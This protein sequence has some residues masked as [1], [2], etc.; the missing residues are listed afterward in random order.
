MKLPII[1][2][3]IVLLLTLIPTPQAYEDWTIDGN[4][5]YIDTPQVY[6]SATPHTLG[7]D[8][9]VTFNFTSKQYTGNIDFVWGF[10]TPATTPHQPQLWCNYSHTLTATR[11]KEKSQTNQF[12][13]ITNYSNLG[14][15]NFHLYNVDFG[16]T[17]NTF[18]YHIYDQFG[19][20]IIAFT[21]FNLEEETT[22][23]Y[24]DSTEQYTYQQSYFDWKP[25]TQ[26]F[27]IINYEYQDMNT[28]YLL[29]NTPITQGTEY[30]IRAWIDIP[31]NGLDNSSGKYWWAFKPYSET[32]Q[33]SIS[34]NHFYC[35]DPWWNSNWDYMCVITIDTDFITTA[36]GPNI[37]VL[38][39][40]QPD[41]VCECDGGDSIRFLSLDNT[42]EFNYEIEYWD[43]TCVYPS[44]VW[45]NISEQVIVSGDYQFLM[46]YGNAGA[47]DNQ[48][49]P[50]TW[51]G[52]YRL[53][54]HMNDSTASTVYDSTINANHGTKVGAGEPSI[55]VNGIAGYCQDGDGSNDYINFQAEASIDMTN[56]PSTIELWIKDTWPGANEILCGSGR[57]TK[58]VGL[59][60]FTGA[61][62]EL[63]VGTASSPRQV[64]NELYSNTTWNHI[65]ITYD[66]SG[67]TN[68][69]GYLNGNILSEEANNNWGWAGNDFYAFK[70]PTG[71]N[72]GGNI[73]ELRIHNTEYNESEVLFHY[74]SG[75]NTTGF[76][77]FSCGFKPPSD[78]YLE[79]Q[80]HSMFP[81]DGN[82]SVCPCKAAFCINISQ[83]ESVNMNF[84]AYINSTYNSTYTIMRNISNITNGVYCWCMCEPVDTYDTTY[85]WYI[86]VTLWNS[87]AIYNQ[88]SNYSFTTVSNPSLCEPTFTDTDTDTH[89]DETWIVGLLIALFGYL[90]IK[91]KR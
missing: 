58:A 78:D 11:Y 12:N 59:Y 34:N 66:S 65:V 14:I 88:S 49:K 1:I 29:P 55:A 47:S 53:V 76:I 84:T 77:T 74:H 57:D 83:N 87:T 27:N 60:V 80:I 21:S 52:N 15:E 25:F 50:G 51:N 64:M 46:Y 63:I 82:T 70:R 26:E 71:S 7:S 40:I 37:P 6:A 23:S 62:I 10:D 38:L 90:Y 36:V 48:D 43:D 86:N 20:Y 33:E 69:T 61:G 91:R 68:P 44:Y 41:I 3:S 42:T 17:N 22:T 13:N 24:Y 28:W 56:T 72:F 79:P 85:H 67:V 9:W 5:V 39:I 16:N 81:A 30:S 54:C 35:L 8:G 89:S 73:D 31:F 75:N 2:I 32:L 4:T 45:V 19:N 18:L